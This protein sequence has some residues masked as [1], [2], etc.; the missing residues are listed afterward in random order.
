MKAIEYV[1]TV[2]LSFIM[3]RWLVLIFLSVQQILKGI[4]S[5]VSNLIIIT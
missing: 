3:L 1:F 4:L 2:E 5:F